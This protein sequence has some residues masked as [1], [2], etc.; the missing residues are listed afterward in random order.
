M[1]QRTV[2]VDDID[3]GE[4]SET[5]IFALDGTSYEIDLSDENAAQLRDA[6]AE[7]IAHARNTNSRMMRRG[8]R[9]PGVK[10]ITT[11]NASIRA[12]ARDEGLA[13][14]DRGRIPAEIIEAYNA[15]H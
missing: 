15:A 8:G 10:A 13:V 11:D 9:R 5:V 2:L 1:A 3:G 7:W 6:F 14:S 12:W 4:A